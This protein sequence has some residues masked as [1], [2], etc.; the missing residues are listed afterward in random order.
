MN[1][2]L[3]SMYK[4]N[5]DNNLSVKVRKKYPNGVYEGEFKNGKK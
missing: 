4:L 5:T 1:D 2:I 3:R